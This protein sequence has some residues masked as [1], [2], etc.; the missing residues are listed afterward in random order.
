MK[1]RILALIMAAFMLFALTACGDEDF[2]DDEPNKGAPSGATETPSDDGGDDDWL[3]DL[4]GDEDEELG[5]EPSCD[6][7]SWAVYWYLCGSDLETEGGCATTDIYELMSVALPEDVTVVI[8]TGGAYAWHNDFVDASVLQRYVYDS[9]GLYLVDE[10][11]SA[12]MGDP[13]T[14]ADFLSFASTNYPADKTAVIF[15]NHGGGSVSGAAF[16]EIYGS[17]SLTLDEMRSA[18]EAVYDLSGDYAPLELVGFDTCLMATVDVASTFVGV[19]NYLVGSEEVEPGN[20]WSY[21]GW[22][23]AL[24]EDPSIYGEEFGRA[25][26][27]SYY[28]GCEMVGTHESA[29]LALIDLNN[30]TPLLDAYE[31]FGA[32]ALAAACED[33]AFFSQFARAANASENYGGNT[34]EEGYTN[35]VDLGHLARQTAELL[36]S[37]GDVLAA[38]DDCVLYTVAGPYRA[39]ATG[40]SCYYSY[41][42]DLA[43]LEGY[44]NVGAGSA[45]KYY[46]T[47]GLTGNLDIDGMEYVSQY[48]ETEYNELPDLLTIDDLEIESR[49]LDVDDEGTAFLELGPMAVDIVA[50]A[51]FTL[52][53]LEEYTGAQ[54]LLGT[55]NDMVV[56]WE[57]GIFYDNFRQKWGAINGELVYME[58]IFT[59]DDYNIYSCPILLNG[60]GYNLRVVYDFTYEEWYI[61]GASHG[62]DE[63]GMAD[64]ELRMLEYGDEIT[65]LLYL[66][67]EGEEEFTL[68]ES[69]TI[70]VD[71]NTTFAETTL[72]DG[73]YYMVYDFWDAMG[74]SASSDGVSFYCYD[75]EITTVVYE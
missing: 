13:N 41:S 44:N 51:G 69:A 54:M 8:E 34:R 26:C 63:C 33:P 49:T 42:G 10:Q 57:N 56:D 22:L 25:I 75:G 7:S 66:A 38:L 46:F 70:T 19:A 67:F 72:P 12:S 43:D 4:L 14:L 74:G 24:A 50:D 62:I 37:S 61:L 9:D 1:K 64:K 39:E 59:G 20:G 32:E 52:Y 36:P 73:E 58:L 55:D 53:W 47:Y 16:D 5:D 28:A 40:L 68:Y 23:S 60:E 65:T 11:P 27:D 48:A 30:V 29:T 15:W 3:D 17:D 6:G 35:M 18:F 2:L 45:F 21:D 31:A 71:E